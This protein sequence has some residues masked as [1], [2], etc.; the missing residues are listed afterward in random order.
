MRLGGHLVPVQHVVLEL[1]IP[2]RF[3]ILHGVSYIDRGQPHVENRGH[4]E[5]DVGGQ[6]Q[7]VVGLAVVVGAV[8]RHEDAVRGDGNGARLGG[9]DL[10]HV[11]PL[12]PGPGF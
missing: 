3:V 8:V 9:I 6:L 1:P 12:F 10:L 2:E 4:E 5:E 7:E 11:L